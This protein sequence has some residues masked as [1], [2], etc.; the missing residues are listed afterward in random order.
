MV[1]CV[2]SWCCAVYGLG[3]VWYE[4]VSVLFC[5]SLCDNVGCVDL[6]VS[7]LRTVT[8]VQRP[9]PLDGTLYDYNIVNGMICWA[10]QTQISPNGTWIAGTYRTEEYDKENDEV[11]QAN[12][13]AF[14]NTE[15][16]TTTVFDEYAGCVAMGVTDDG[17]GLIGIQ[18]MGVNSGFIVDLASKTK[19]DD[20]LP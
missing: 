17:L 20:M 10:N 8:T 1:C 9:N 3:V 2:L 5:W 16:K 11:L 14:F 7:D 6:G 15:T 19:V 13:P 4:L 18:G 12:Y